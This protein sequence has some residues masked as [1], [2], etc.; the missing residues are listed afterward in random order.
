MSEHAHGNANPGDD[1]RQAYLRGV[2]LLVAGDPTAA[3]EHLRR[4]SPDEWPEARLA[5]AKAHLEAGQGA[6]AW[7]LLQALQRTGEDGAYLDLLSAS[8]AALDG[9]GA[10]AL[11]LLEDIP[12]RDSRLEYACHQ[13]RRRIEKDRPPSVRL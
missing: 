8:A 11:A 12:S 10:D 1:V 13:L 4:I 5:L 7:D 6:E 3:I 9:R 2:D